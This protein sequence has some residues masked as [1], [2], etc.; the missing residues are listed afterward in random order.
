MEVFRLSREKYA[1]I[2]S[3]KGAALRGAR[4]NSVGSELIYT[5]CNRSLAMADVAVHLTIATLPVDFVMMTLEIP[6][7]IELSK[8]DVFNLLLNWNAF[9]HPSTTPQI[10]DSFII[11]NKYCVLQVPSSVTKG[12]YNLLINPKHPDFKHISIIN[13][14]PFPFDRRMFR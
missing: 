1:N 3:G 10:G 6:D 14:E 11:E 2:L 13:T 9:P 12:D 7:T 8:I 4:W 5:A